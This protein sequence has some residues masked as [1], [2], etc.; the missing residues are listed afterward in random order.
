[1]IPKAANDGNW[2]TLWHTQA[3][4][5]GKG[6]WM[7]DLGA[8]HVIQRVTILPRQDMYQEHAQKNIE[9][10][11]SNDP[12]F[13]TYTVLCEQNDVPWYRKHG[14][15]HESNMWEKFIPEMEGFRYLRV[16][17]TLPAGQLNFADFG[18]FGYPE[19]PQGAGT[20]RRG[21]ARLPSRNLGE[22]WPKPAW[23]ESG[24]RQAAPLQGAEKI[25]RGF[26][27]L[28]SRNLGEGWPKPAW[29]RKRVPTSGTPTGRRRNS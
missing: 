20:I 1:M 18:A 2:N 24:C 23:G 10:Q 12:A 25:R 27:R 7:V 16:K 14:G 4:G 22:G 17:S 11:G 13:G 3:D 9:V 26:A 21:F 15:S 29:G 6:W 28:P 19:A 5:D 8:P